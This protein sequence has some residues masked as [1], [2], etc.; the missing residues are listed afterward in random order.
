MHGVVVGA[1]QCTVNPALMGLLAACTVRYALP[2]E[3][4]GITN[5][6]QLLS[7][8]VSRHLCGG[9][10]WERCSAEGGSTWQFK[11]NAHRLDR[12]RGGTAHRLFGFY[13]SK[14]ALCPFGAK[15]ILHL[16]RQVRVANPSLPM[17]QRSKFLLHLELASAPNPNVGAGSAHEIGRRTSAPG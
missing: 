17:A 3:A 10:K 14:D 13:S 2:E 8:R 9:G 7:E 16:K 4:G 5:K 1:I 15:R 6:L 11:G 12:G